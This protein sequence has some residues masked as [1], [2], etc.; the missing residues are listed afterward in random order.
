MIT[1]PLP[2]IFGSSK[3]VRADAKAAKA[4]SAAPSVQANTVATVESHADAY[5]RAARMVLPHLWAAVVG[6]WTCGFL[7]MLADL[8][9]LEAILWGGAV[10]TL[11]ASVVVCLRTTTACDGA[12][13][14][15]VSAK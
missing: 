1:A 15:E 9:V 11:L 8:P 3:S 5:D 6:V 12:S 10:A 4:P 7:I 2:S 13:M 14:A